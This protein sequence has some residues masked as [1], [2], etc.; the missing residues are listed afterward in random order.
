M[1]DSAPAGAPSPSS[2]PLADAIGRLD[3][4]LAAL[5]AALARRLDVEARRGD[6]ETELS[7]M[8]D[9]RARLA[10]DLD[11]A[12]SRLERLEMA[13]ADVDRRVER[14]MGEIRAAIAA[15][16]ATPRD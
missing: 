16:E 14:A 3:L 8:Q 13:A 10:A 7:V 12:L 4:A 1:A 15:A 6:L 2:R 5:E 9:D 11:G